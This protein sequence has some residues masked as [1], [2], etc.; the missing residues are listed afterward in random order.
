M[1]DET[2][3]TREVVAYTARLSRV[4]LADDDMDTLAPEI[5]G[6]IAHVARLNELDT[7]GVEP[8]AHVLPLRNVMRDDVPTASLSNEDALRSA[9]ETADGAFRVPRIIG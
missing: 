2:P 8:T 6:I 3:I 5:Q 4:A 1:S 9:P 7:D